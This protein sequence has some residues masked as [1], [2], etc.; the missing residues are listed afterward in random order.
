[1]T[2]SG[3]RPIDTPARTDG[4]R[5]A[6]PREDAVMVL[7]AAC[8]VGG[9]LS[10]GWAHANV[11]ETLEG[12]FTPWHGLL[13]A[14]FAGSAAWTFWLAY[15]RRDQA[16]R[17]WRDGW[18]AG[19]RLGAFGVLLF[20]TGGLADMVWHET[21][22]I[23]VGLEATFS[24]SHMLLDVGG[25]LIVTSPLRSWWATGR[26]AIAGIVSVTL[27]AMAAT[28]LLTH[29]SAFMTMAPTQPYDGVDGD[30][31]GLEGMTRLVA[32]TGVSS[33]VITTLLLT[34]PLLLVLRRRPAPGAATAVTAG[35]ALFIMV[36]FEFPAAQAAGAIAAVCG[37]AVADALLIRFDRV[38]GIGAP[39]R[40]MI[41]GALFPALVW[42]GQLLGLHLAE[43]VR[44]PAEMWT[45]VIVFT[46]ILGALLGTLAGGYAGQPAGNRQ[47]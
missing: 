41:A 2:I 43:G 21:I 37:A 6:T 5:A 28:I 32:L 38:R 22:G 13:Y 10:D 9:A 24:P 18:P 1:M 3:V 16:P 45:G 30:A 29:S 36:M 26:G 8:L 4:V 35:V 46:A 40:L 20:L 15:Q 42:S 14:G 33:Y 19:Y 17:W 47:S 25:V 44:W 31:S 27:G 39:L 11:I 34:V 23:E 12:F 7:L